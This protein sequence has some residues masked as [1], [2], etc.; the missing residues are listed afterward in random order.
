MTNEVRFRAYDALLRPTATGGCYWNEVYVVDTHICFFKNQARRC[1]L[2]LGKT[3]AD[4]VTIPFGEAYR[5]KYHCE[6]PKSVQE[7]I[8][9]YLDQ[10]GELFDGKLFRREVWRRVWRH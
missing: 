3:E 6:P 4:I 5:A 8:D 7:K 10:R 2:W 1:A 9:I